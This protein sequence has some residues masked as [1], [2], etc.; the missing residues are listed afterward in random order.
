MS[1]EGSTEATHDSEGV[2]DQQMVR[3]IA[4]FGGLIGVVAVIL[5]V[6]AIVIAG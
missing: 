6:I 5:A 4:L 2:T 1:E 3:N